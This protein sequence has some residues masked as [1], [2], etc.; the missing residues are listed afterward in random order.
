MVRKAENIENL[1]LTILNV[2]KNHI[3]VSVQKPEASRAAREATQ[4]YSACEPLLRL[5]LR[6]GNVLG[7]KQGG[8][9]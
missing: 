3:K 4:F 9:P 7:T 8:A 2:G 1:R 5:H 6:A